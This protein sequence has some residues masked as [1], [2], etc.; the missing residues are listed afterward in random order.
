MNINVHHSPTS[1][2]SNPARAQAQALGC[3]SKEMAPLLAGVL[4]DRG[5]RGL[6]FRGSDGR[7]KITTSGPSTIFEI[8]NGRVEQHELNPQDFG[9]PLVSV[10]ALAGRDGKYNAEIVRK[11]LAGELGPVRD[12][13]LLNTAAGLTAYDKDASEHLFERMHKNVK[14][15]EESIDSGAAQQVLD[16]WVKVSRPEPGN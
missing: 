15:A 14:R 5:V 12:A 6:V 3:A 9:I 1:G 7:D 16:R 10:E 11:M 4:A 13:V 2:L 8:R